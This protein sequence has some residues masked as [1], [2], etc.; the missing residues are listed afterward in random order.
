MLTALLDITRARLFDCPFLPFL[1]DH[2]VLPLRRC[3]GANRTSYFANVAPT[4][5][6]SRRA[7]PGSNGIVII[8]RYRQHLIR[9]NDPHHLEYMVLHYTERS[10]KWAG[11][12]MTSI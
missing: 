12:R 4:N 11:K 5:Y 2:P 3:T 1:F 9:T 7:Y 6:L 10:R 8:A